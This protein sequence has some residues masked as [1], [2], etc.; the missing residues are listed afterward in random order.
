MSIDRLHTGRN[1]FLVKYSHFEHV[2]PSLEALLRYLKAK[3]V[4]VI[5]ITRDPMFVFLSLKDKNY[6]N[7]H[8][9]GYGKHRVGP[10]EYAK[11]AK[12]YFATAKT[13][14]AALRSAGV[15]ALELSYEE[16]SGRGSLEAWTR[17][18]R[19]LGVDDGPA[20]DPNLA[21][22]VS[23]CGRACGRACVRACVSA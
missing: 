6:K 18:A 16:L 22:P 2:S 14:A 13:W 23:A 10:A 7:A 15:P 11:F 12:E 9:S 5:H 1:G 19:F 17:F 8:G 21:E 3:G 4:G 20:E